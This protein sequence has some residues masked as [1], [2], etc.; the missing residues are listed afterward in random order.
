MDK[1]LEAVGSNGKFQMIL[2]VLIS[3][4]QA[5]IAVTSTGI[6]YLSKSPEFNCKQRN[7]EISNFKECSSEFYCLN[8]LYEYEKN[9]EKSLYNLAYSFDLYCENKIYLQIMS[10]CLFF[11]GII[12]IFFFSPLPDKYGRLK[13]YKMMCLGLAMTN[14]SLFFTSGT[15]HLILNFFA[16]GIFVFLNSMSMTIICEFMDK[17]NAGKVMG[18]NNA[19]FPLAGIIMAVYFMLINNWRILFLINMVSSLIVVYFVFVYMV[20]SPRWLNSKYKH[21]EL[22]ESLMKIAVFNGNKDKFTK[23]LEENR[24]ILENEESLS[25]NSINEE[26]KTVNLITIFFIPKFRYIFISLLFCWWSIGACFWGL[27]FN[28]EHLG[29]SMYIDSIITFGAELI[30]ELSSGYYSDIFGRRKVMMIST[31]FGGICYIIFDFFQTG[32]IKTVLLFFA[33]VGMS[34]IFNVLFIYSPEA[35]PTSVRSSNVIYCFSCRW[36]DVSIYDKFL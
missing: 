12:S 11:G 20:E 31:I 5:I 9:R 3:F 33:A 21:K 16:F 22:I 6:P 4:I 24:N 36:Y 8:E 19:A 28:L 13:I 35:F 29:S 2:A 17:N 27:I 1:A 34:S 30:A 32:L 26:Q 10:S 7:I 23:F 25:N 18:I 14:I 15:Y